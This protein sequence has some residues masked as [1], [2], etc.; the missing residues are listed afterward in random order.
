MALGQ[1]YEE[2]IGAEK[3][4]NK[5]LDF[6]ESAANHDEPYALYKIGLFLE[7]G[8]HRDC[9]DGEPELHEALKYFKIAHN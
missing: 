6:Y 9:L 1:M 2:G 7:K 3:D 8:I 4:V 5:A